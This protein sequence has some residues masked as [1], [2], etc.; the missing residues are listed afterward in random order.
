MACLALISASSLR[1]APSTFPNNKSKP[2]EHWPARCMHP[3]VGP[4]P[5]P[6]Q[7]HKRYM[8]PGGN[9]NRGKEN[10]L[11]LSCSTRYRTLR[12]AIWSVICPSA[13]AVPS[14]SFLSFPAHSSPT[15]PASSKIT[16]RATSP[17][18]PERGETQGEITLWER[19]KKKGG[20]WCVQQSVAESPLTWLSVGV[21]QPAFG[22]AHLWLNQSQW[23]L[24][25]LHI[26]RQR[27]KTVLYVTRA[28]ADLLEIVK[29][30]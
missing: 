13:F 12:S 26:L 8:L 6:C 27:E 24:Q 5:L 20:I 1:A 18:S 3:G 14:M 11:D 2:C 7:K 16:R 23:S 25:S 21:F 9:T 19:E 28:G 22:L 15:L 30:V 4:W 10:S 29:S 17:G